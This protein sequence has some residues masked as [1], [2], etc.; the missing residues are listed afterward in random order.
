MAGDRPGTADPERLLAELGESL[1]T[2]LVAAVPGWVEREVQRIVEAWDSSGPPSSEE[3]GDGR[4]AVGGGADRAAVLTE[5]REAG[6]RAAE[7]VGV[8]L[9]GVLSAGVDEQATTPLEVIRG[10]VAYPTSVL[11]SAGVPGVV[12]DSFA[13]ARFPDDIYGLTPASLGAVDASLTD[14]AR[15]WGAAKAMA[16]KARH[17]VPRA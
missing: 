15:A 9:R 7:E 5:A 11:L 4:P 14:P 10:V 8:R 17:G 6:R 12:R 16:H 2:Q 13:E 3:G 1:R